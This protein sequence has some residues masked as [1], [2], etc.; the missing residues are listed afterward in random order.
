MEEF[1]LIGVR[2]IDSS[3]SLGDLK[4]G[5]NAFE[6]CM[7]VLDIPEEHLLDA[8]LTKLGL[9]VSLYDIDEDIFLYDD[10]WYIQL[11]RVANTSA[12]VA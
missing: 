5:Y 8:R 4:E 10:D 6:Y 1:F 7:Q 3:W 11:K 12:R 2:K 9:E